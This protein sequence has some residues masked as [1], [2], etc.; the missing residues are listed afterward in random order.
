MNELIQRFERWSFTETE[1]QSGS[2]ANVLK[3][4]ENQTHLVY[5]KT[6]SNSFF[7]LFLERLRLQAVQLWK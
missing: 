1:K 4:K 5:Y 6:W 7:I 3:N 2:F